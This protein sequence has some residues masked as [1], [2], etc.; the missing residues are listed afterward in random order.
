[1]E[2]K[3]AEQLFGTNDQA[4]AQDSSVFSRLL[5]SLLAHVLLVSVGVAVCAALMATNDTA[6]ILAYVGTAVVCA[7]AGLLLA[8]KKQLSDQAIA[9]LSCLAM[10]I[11]SLVAAGDATLLFMSNLLALAATTIVALVVDNR[12]ALGLGLLLYSLIS[13]VA[14]VM[15]NPLLPTVAPWMWLP[16]LVLGG[17]FV[18][19]VSQL[20]TTLVAELKVRDKSK[21]WKHTPF[22]LM[23]SEGPTSA[24]Q[25]DLLM[26]TAPVGITVLD[27]RGEIIGWNRRNEE[28]LGLRAEDVVGM[29]FVDLLLRANPDHPMIPRVLGLYQS[30]P[31]SH[32]VV[33]TP[34]E[35]GTLTLLMSGAPTHNSD[36]DISGA[37]LVGIDI[38][39]LQ[40]VAEASAQSPVVSAKDG[41]LSFSRDLSSKVMSLGLSIESVLQQLQDDAPDL[42]LLRSRMTTLESQHRQAA[43][44]LNIQAQIK[45]SA[46][47]TRKPPKASDMVEAALGVVRPRLE[48]VGIKLIVENELEEDVLLRAQAVLARQI[49]VNLLTQARSQLLDSGDPENRW[50]SVNLRRDGN[51]AC[52]VIS[53]SSNREVPT[54]PKAKFEAFYGYQPG[55]TGSDVGLALSRSTAQHLG[56]DISVEAGE[57]G[58]VIT[59]SLPIQE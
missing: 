51:F 15:E 45:P 37:I 28:F 27:E 29:R 35:Q 18:V 44:A 23:R 55:L 54:D 46:G 50:V 10:G 21:A 8:R 19:G 43:D 42:E 11:S 33:H 20:V 25:M 24:D 30:H 5:Q 41:S 39:P 13:V 17:V 47:D 4:A 6:K 56:G 48:A 59:V 12:V 1:M 38:T 22:R 52:F 36:G 40:L 32:Q 9:Y 53:D 7:I 49:L 58:P 34:S 16:V 31:F 3:F 2:S 14:W 57:S 26:G